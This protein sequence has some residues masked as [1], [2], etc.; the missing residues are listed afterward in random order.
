MEPSRPYHDAHRPRRETAARLRSGSAGG[1]ARVGTTT[2]LVL[3][4][5]SCCGALLLMNQRP[6]LLSLCQGAESPPRAASGVRTASFEDKNLPE[7]PRRHDNRRPMSRR[8][9]LENSKGIALGIGL[10]GP[11]RG[12]A[13]HGASAGRAVGAVAAG[14]WGLGLGQGGV[15]SAEAFG[16]PSRPLSRCLVNAVNAREFCRRLEAD[17]AAGRNEQECRG[18]VKGVLRGLTLQESI[19]DAVLYLPRGKRQAAGDAGQSAVEY[20][21]SVV[22]FDAWDKL[23]KDWTSNVALRNMTPENVM[24]VRMALDASGSA[25]DTFLRQFES[26]DV[27]SARELYRLYFLPAEEREQPTGI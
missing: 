7:D 3:L 20:L 15:R 13:L 27:D 12:T 22:E 25:L 23:D 11:M 10:A 18:M 26:A 4:H 21:A 24:F 6:P 8:N 19:K 16:G 17:L 5:L 14:S 2:V 9:L 1:L